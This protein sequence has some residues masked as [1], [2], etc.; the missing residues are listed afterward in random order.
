MES[1]TYLSENE[2]KEFEFGEDNQNG[3]PIY[4]NKKDDDD[5]DEEKKRRRRRR[6]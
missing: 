5:Y 2:L 6:K 1:Y 4:D 3:Q